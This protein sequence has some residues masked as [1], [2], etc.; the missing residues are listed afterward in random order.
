VR[1]H[2][3]LVYRILGRARVKCENHEG[4]CSWQGEL[5]ELAI[6]LAGC[7]QTM[8][9]CEDC[10]ARVPRE[11]MD[12]HH[13]QCTRQCEV[14]LETSEV[15]HILPCYWPPPTV[16]ELQS[17][18]SQVLICT[19]RKPTPLSPLIHRPAPSNRLLPC[20]SSRSL[21]LSWDLLLSVRRIAF[22]PHLTDSK[23]NA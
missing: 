4:G 2:N 15:I 3:P 22:H 20:T 18:P 1:E 23:L 12:M 7:P 19:S 16:G 5:S 10:G 6:H 11:Q 13:F 8:V 9:R 14:R 17:N 21:R